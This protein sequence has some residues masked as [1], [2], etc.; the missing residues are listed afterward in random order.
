[1]E[2]SAVGQTTCWEEGR[3]GWVGGREGGREGED[4]KGEGGGKVEREGEGGG[5][6]S[7]EGGD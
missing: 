3:Y 6:R 4:E 7:R 5:R 1:M 2:G